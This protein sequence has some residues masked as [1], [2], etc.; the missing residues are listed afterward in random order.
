MEFYGLIGEKL[1]HS[2]SESIHQM[3]FEL[4]GIRGAYKLMEI[5]AGNLRRLP[6]ALRLVGM[7]GINVTIPYKRKIMKHLDWIDEDAAEGGAVNTSLLTGK[8][9]HGFNTDVEGVSRLLQREGISVAGK[10][11]VVLGSGGAARATVMALKKEGIRTVYVVTRDLRKSGAQILGAQL[12]DYEQ[13]AGISGDLLINCT[14]VGMF[15]NV[16]ASVVGR[17]V[18]E[19]YDAVVDTIY[20][21]TQTRLLQYGAEM[22]KKNANGLYMLV[23][24]AMS[25]QEIWQGNPVEEAVTEQIFQNLNEGLK[26]SQ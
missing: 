23:A 17:S 18:V 1:G 3:F 8:E 16:D 11:A 4:T 20:N 5:P 19:R 9:L 26:G 25:A 12:I 21:P 6:D 14:P 7:R 24:Q 22:G 13:L 2:L 15:P 10:Q